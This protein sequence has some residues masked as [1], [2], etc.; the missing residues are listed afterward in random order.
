[1][2]NEST[3]RT[4]LQRTP[5]IAGVLAASTPSP[6][7]AIESALERAIFD[8][9]RFEA[10]GNAHTKDTAAVQSAIDEAGRQGGCVYFPPGRYL[11]GTLR[12]RSHVTIQL[13]NGAT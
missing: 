1:M 12:L 3:R 9:R 11:C 10:K 6:A 7:L 5:L 2:N 8:V 4:F 13:E